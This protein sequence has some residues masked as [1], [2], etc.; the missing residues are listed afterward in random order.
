M[1]VANFK[2]KTNVDQIIRSVARV[3]VY[4]GRIFC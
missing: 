1:D 4:N 3:L 2:I